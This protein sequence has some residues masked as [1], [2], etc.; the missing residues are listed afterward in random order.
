VYEGSIYG[1]FDLGP[2]L[3]LLCVEK[4]KE[5]ERKRKN[6]EKAAARKEKKEILKKRTPFTIAKN[7]AKC[8]KK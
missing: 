3:C 8:R 2:L 1:R 6:R 7:L 4:K 5:E